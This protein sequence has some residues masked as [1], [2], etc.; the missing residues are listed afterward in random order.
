MLLNFKNNVT[1]CNLIYTERNG[2]GKITIFIVT[3]GQIQIIIK[4]TTLYSKNSYVLS[5]FYY[6]SLI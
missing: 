6:K 3:V 5:N 1:K 4:F 2:L